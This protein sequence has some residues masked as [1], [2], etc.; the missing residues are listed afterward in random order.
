MTAKEGGE[1]AENSLRTGVDDVARG[2][3][4]AEGSSQKL[5][6]SDRTG[7][8]L[9]E[10][11]STTVSKATDFYVTPKGEAVPSTVYRVWGDEAGGSGRSWTTVNPRTVT[12]YRDAAVRFAGW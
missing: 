1:I 8:L 12:V 6:T 9:I 10:N 11:Q 4:G 3:E 2:V 5:L 7:Q